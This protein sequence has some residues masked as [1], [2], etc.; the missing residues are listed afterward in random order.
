MTAFGVACELMVE[1]DVL[2][3]VR[4]DCLEEEDELILDD[5]NDA[6]EDADEDDDEGGDDALLR[7]DLGLPRSSEKE[8]IDELVR[9][10]DDGE[11]FELVVR[12]RLLSESV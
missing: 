4:I 8:R 2:M 11:G 3:L 6:D 1:A 10:S 12:G 7:V 5:D 9:D